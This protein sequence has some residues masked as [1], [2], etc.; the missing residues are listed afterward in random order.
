MRYMAPKWWFSIIFVTVVN[1]Y[2]EAQVYDLFVIKGNSAIFKC[3]LP[4][5]VSDHLE[6]ISWEDSKGNKYSLS[7]DNKVVGRDEF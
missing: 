2:Y 5:F 4:S 6:V 1:Q 3:N 7:T